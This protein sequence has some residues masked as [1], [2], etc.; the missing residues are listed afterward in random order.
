VSNCSRCRA[1]DNGDLLGLAWL[2]KI[3]S[4]AGCSDQFCSRQARRQR[5][6]WFE[7]KFGFAKKYLE[8]RFW[9]G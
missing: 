4:D 6:G 7:H 1:H 3:A 9:L 5:V 2:S 8:Q